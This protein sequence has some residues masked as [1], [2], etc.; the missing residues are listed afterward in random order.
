MIHTHAANR[1]ITLLGLSAIVLTAGLLS[2]PVSGADGGQTP[3]AQGYAG[4][5]SCRECH[6]RFYQL[7]S[8][9]FHG[10]AM[11]P[12]SE[13]LAREKLTTQSEDLAIGPYRYRAEIDAGQGWVREEGP[14]G[15]KKYPMAHAMGGKNVWYF[16]TPL[17]KGKLQTLPLAYDVREKRWIDMAG[18]GVRHFPGESGPDE[19]FTWK[20]WPYTFNTACYGCHVSQLSTNYDLKTDSYS[21]TWAEPGINCEACH[22]PSAAHNTAARALAKGQP[23]TE[24]KL[25]STRTMTKAQRNDLCASCHAKA[26]APLAA[27][28][29]PGDKFFDHYDLVTLENPDFYP[30]G[31][32]LGENYTLTSWRMSPCVKSGQI[33]CIHCHTSSGR[34]RFKKAED[35]N[36]ACLPC[37][38]VRVDKASEHSRHAEGSEGNKCIACHMPMTS[39]ARMNRSDHSMLPPAPAASLAYQSPNA[40]TL[41]HTDKDAAWADTLVRQWR[42]RD[43]QA[44]LLHRAGLVDAAR[45]GDFRRRGEMLRYIEGPER[46]EIFATSLIRLI[47][48]APDAALAATLHKAMQD[49]SPLVRAAAVETLATMPSQ[50]NLQALVMAAGDDSRLVRIRAAAALVNYPEPQGNNPHVVNMKKAAEEYRTSLMVRPDLWSSH[51]NLGNHYLARGELA[52]AVAAYDQALKFEP[53]AAMVLVNAALAQARLGDAGKAE[54]SLTKAI[55][56]A[57]TNAAALFNLGLLKAEQNDPARAEQSLRQALKQDPQMAQAAYNLCI[58]LG[59]DKPAEALGFCREAVKL[60]PDEPK[61]G[62]TLAYTLNRQGG[63][64][65]ATAL[66]RSMVEK[67]PQYQDAALLLKEIETG[68][69][70]P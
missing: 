61:Y 19:H 70:Q 25:I 54:A 20:E 59:T 58:L 2:S 7:W 66:L 27:S 47:P 50:E 18:S 22:G 3:A 62:F 69:K 60:R 45:K 9:S 24:L 67:Y 40:C 1:I 23:L 10:L 33:D 39:F 6:E 48:P 11:Q 5:P 52:A 15:S 53:R 63:Q 46:D 12:Y 37:H 68:G 43:Y 21:T 51:Y 16:L 49:P 8:T 17:D 30:D 64:A 13:A 55:E 34:Y 41:C 36:R 42:G 65:E 26:T 57:P 29:S 4:S 14:E 44:P 35:A 56:I 38:Q 32:D 28:F 31:R